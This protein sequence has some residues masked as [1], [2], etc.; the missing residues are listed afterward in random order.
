MRLTVLSLVLTVALASVLSTAHRAS[1]AEA[2]PH[3][4]SIMAA[5]QQ[6][7]QPVP[8]NDDSRVGVQVGVLCAAVGLV[9]VVGTCAYFARRVLGLSGPPPPQD[10]AGHH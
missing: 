7:P 2:A 5:H 10:A 4:Q 6:T 3:G 9:V 8:S 1:A